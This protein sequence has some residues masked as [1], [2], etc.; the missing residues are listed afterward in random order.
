MERALASLEYQALTSA[1][2]VIY[3]RALASTVGRFLPLGGYAE[4]ATPSRPRCD[5]VWERCLRLAR[6]GW[7]VARLVH[8][9]REWVEEIRHLSRLLLGRDLPAHLPVSM[10][11]NLGSGVYE[12]SETP[13]GELE[14]VIDLVEFAQPRILTIVCDVIGGGVALY[15]PGASTN[16]LAG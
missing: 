14:T 10:F 11:A 1:N 12:K 4:P 3:D 15:P 7:S 6:E 8:P 5:G 13:L 16:G 9:S 2:V